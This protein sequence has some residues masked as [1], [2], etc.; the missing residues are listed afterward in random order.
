MEQAGKIALRS[1]RREARTFLQVSGAHR[2]VGVGLRSAWCVHGRQK[3]WGGIEFTRERGD[4]DFD[5]REVG[6]LHRVAPHLGSGLRASA[7]LSQTALAEPGGAEG[8]G[9]LI[10]DQQGRVVEHTEAAWRDL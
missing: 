2:P 8:P 6:L 3:G 5:T 1:D 10:L 4:P 7:L 9:V